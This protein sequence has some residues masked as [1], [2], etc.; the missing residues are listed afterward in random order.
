MEIFSAC[1][2]MQL[3]LSIFFEK[4]FQNQSTL[5]FLFWA[6]A[7]GFVIWLPL[8]VLQGIGLYTMSKRQGL[9]HSWMAFVPL[10]NILC[11]GKV[12]GECRFFN[13]K[14]KNAGVYALIAQILATIAQM[15]TFASLVYLLVF[16]GEPTIVPGFENGIETSPSYYWPTATT[17]LA[18]AAV[19]YYEQSGAVTFIFGLIYEI[20]IFVLLIA[21]LKKYA[22]NRYF[23]LSTVGLFIPL[24]RHIIIFTLRERN[25]IDYEAMMRARREAYFRRQQQYYQQY[26]NPY[27]RP[28][29]YGTPGGYGNPYGA[30]NTNQQPSQPAPEEP[31]EEF[32]SPTSNNTENREDGSDGFFD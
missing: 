18:S 19:W 8:F 17:G 7:L 16:H 26:G 9:K 20:L 14:M 13:H 3:V 11:L 10:L 6:F 29:G 27:G 31:F 2:I 25:A 15:L 22:P 24:S 28:G 1:N 30:P 5:V 4:A 21:L 12:A 32:A 23:M